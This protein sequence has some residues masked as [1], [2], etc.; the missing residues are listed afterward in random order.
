M[1]RGAIMVRRMFLTLAVILMVCSMAWADNGRTS[2]D[3]NAILGNSGMTGTSGTGTGSM[4][5]ILN[6]LPIDSNVAGIIQTIT[7]GSG[8]LNAV[9]GGNTGSS[10]MD[11]LLNGVF[12]QG[13]V[14]TNASSII[15]NVN[16]YVQPASTYSSRDIGQNATIIRANPYDNGENAQQNCRAAADSQFKTILDNQRNNAKGTG[17]QWSNLLQK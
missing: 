11:V 2:I 16:Q 7:G 3:L 6:A 10:I 1:E 8:I 15:Q 14:N 4:A 12:N 13:N 17:Y 5:G 9:D